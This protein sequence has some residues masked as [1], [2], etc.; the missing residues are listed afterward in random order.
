MEWLSNAWAGVLKTGALIVGGIVGAMG[1][2]SVFLTVLLYMMVVDYIT[3]VMVAM[4][5]RSTKTTNGGLSSAVGANGLMKK[6]MI[7]LMVILGTLLDYVI[8]SDG[9]M[10]QTAV[11]SFYIANE[12]LSVL[13][14]AVAIG[15]PVPSV[16]KEALESL[17]EKK[18]G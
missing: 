12:G 8:G 5:H 7:M 2:W 3:G 9:M 17:R 6:G 11:A 15:L 1:G 16:V 4:L 13:E 10:F 18:E 14:N